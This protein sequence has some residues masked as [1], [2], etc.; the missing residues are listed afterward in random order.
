MDGLLETP[1]RNPN[2]NLF[3]L[4][5]SDDETPKVVRIGSESRLTG[6]ETIDAEPEKVRPPPLPFRWH[7]H[8]LCGPGTERTIVAMA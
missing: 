8:A 5:E 4:G 3:A 1:H 2:Q 6:V 7:V